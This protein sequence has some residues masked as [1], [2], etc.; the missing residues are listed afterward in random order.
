MMVGIPCGSSTSTPQV[1]LPE[2]ISVVPV[3]PDGDNNHSTNNSTG[4]TPVI[5]V[6]EVN[7]QRLLPAAPIHPRGSTPRHPQ[8]R[9]PYSIQRSLE[10]TA[11][12]TSSMHP[13]GLS[14]QRSGRMGITTSVSPPIVP[15]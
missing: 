7:E 8:S 13:V 5:P 3:A 1:V 12:V 4:S 15:R 11:F 9:V 10:D 2:G 14:K 6:I